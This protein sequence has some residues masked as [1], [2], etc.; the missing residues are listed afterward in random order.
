MSVHKPRFP[1]DDSRYG[2]AFDPFG[3]LFVEEPA[4][5]LIRF[6][7]E[8]PS[9]G[10]GVNRGP[11]E[12]QR[13]VEAQPLPTGFSQGRRV[14]EPDR[15]GSQSRRVQV[16]PC[17]EE[18]HHAGPRCRSHSRVDRASTQAEAPRACCCSRTPKERSLRDRELSVRLLSSFRSC[19]VLRKKERKMLP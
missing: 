17:S 8:R 3:N 16:H 19:R 13:P 14:V 10:Q 1:G 15:S 9:S 6:T 5:T 2:D 12:I 4:Q 11:I 7:R 18:T